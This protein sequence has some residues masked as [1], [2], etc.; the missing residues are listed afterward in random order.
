M[1]PDTNKVNGVTALNAV[2]GI[3]IIPYTIGVSVQNSNTRFAEN[4]GLSK[5]NISFYFYS[6]KYCFCYTIN[7]HNLHA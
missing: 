1:S 4:L 6:Y 2:C 5:L 7:K 3:T